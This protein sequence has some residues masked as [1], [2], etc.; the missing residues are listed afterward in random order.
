[1]SRLPN[2]RDMDLFRDFG[3]R[4]RYGLF[5]VGFESIGF[6]PPPPSLVSGLLQGLGGFLEPFFVPR[7]N[8]PLTAEGWMVDPCGAMKKNLGDEKPTQLCGANLPQTFISGIP[9]QDNPVFF[10]ESKGPRA[11]FCFFF[12]ANNVFFFFKRRTPCGASKMWPSELVPCPRCRKIR[13]STKQ[14]V[15]RRVCVCVYT[16]FSLIY[17]YI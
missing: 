14:D 17:T 7:V 3:E 4:E 15:R 12:V 11:G 10:M 13:R 5:L 16:F 9:N 6:R 1:M 8:D 2:H